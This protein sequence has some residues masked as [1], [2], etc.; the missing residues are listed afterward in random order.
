MIRYDSLGIP[1][2]ERDHHGT[3]SRERPK[4]DLRTTRESSFNTK[5]FIRRYIRMLLS[6]CLLTGCSF[7]SLHETLSVVGEADSLW[8]QGQMCDDSVR[9]AQAYSTLRV[10]RIFYADA[11]AHACYHYGKL[12]RANDD[13]VAAM[14]VFI[15]ATHSRTHDYHILG[16]VYSNMGSICHLAGDFPLA[17][18]M[19]EQ[20][21]EQ[22][23]RNGDSI[24]YYYALNDMAFEKAMLVEEDA[25]NILIDS[26]KRCRK[27]DTRLKI[28][29]LE[30]EL[31]LR[32]QRYD[33]ARQKALELFKS[34]SNNTLGILVLAQSYSFTN[35]K[36]SATCYAEILLQ[37]SQNISDIHNALYILTNDDS[38][39]KESIRQVASDRSDIQMI[40]KDR[41]GK[42]SQAVQLLEQDLHR[43][44]DYRWLYAILLTL[45]V[46]GACLYVYNY[47]KRRQ[48]ALLSQQV[49]DL[50]IQNK[51]A[52]AQHE[53]IIGDIEKHKRTI[54]DEVEQNCKLIIKAESFP[55]NIY[56]NKYKKMCS[57]VDKR[58]YL[59]ASKLLTKYK[60][61]ETEMRL[62]VLTLL[63]CKYDL[64]ADLLYRS[65]SSIGTLKIRVA[66]KIGTTAK[67]LRMYLIENECIN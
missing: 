34:D 44:P 10:W 50:A 55:Q 2:Q 40:L 16:R 57:I 18:D 38:K 11:Y 64:I 7:R 45:V 17:Y 58:F 12:L 67:N 56:W 39:S 13:P 65:N 63:D 9:L 30:S 60:L 6:L 20:S 28:L 53:K 25:V 42:L 43:K 32:S 8:Q 14:Q 15:D 48:H 36:D 61:N 51:E 19:Y 41:Q 29:E 26:L 62:C 66:K 5:M 3:T 4:N 49:D 27:I 31:Y 54:T 33:S 46:G 1:Y 52:E 24:R 59:L 23:L 37:K 35:Q 21:A 47:R 22:F